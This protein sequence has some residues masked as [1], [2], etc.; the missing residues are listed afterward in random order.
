MGNYTTT[1]NS[2][3][4]EESVNEAHDPPRLQ[5]VVSDLALLKRKMEEIYLER[6]KF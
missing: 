6:K 1:I 4:Q 2:G 5:G 3:S